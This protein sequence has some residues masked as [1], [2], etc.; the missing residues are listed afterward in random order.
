MDIWSHG[1]TTHSNGDKVYLMNSMCD[2]TRFVVSSIT[3][4]ID[5]ATL[6]QLFIL[7]VVLSFGMCSVVVINDELTFKGA[8]IAMCQALN[9]FYW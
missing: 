8:F 7:D 2:L 3:Y 5:S 6:V 9:I 4:S 1:A